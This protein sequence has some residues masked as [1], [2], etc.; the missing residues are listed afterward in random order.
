VRGA[1]AVGAWLSRAT[2]T[3]PGV[4]LGPTAAERLGV[5]TPGTRVWL[6]GQW[7]GVTGILSPIPLAPELD[8][9]ALVGWPA[10]ERYLGFDG[11]PTSV[12]VRSATAQVEAVRNVLPG[13]AN[14]AAPNEVRVSRPSDAL[15]ARR[16]TDQALGSLLLGLGAV[17]LLVGAIGVA[18]TMVISVLERRAEI[19]LRRSLGATSKQIRLQF[20]TESVL[21]S[22]L[23]GLAGVLLGTGVLAGG[24]ATGGDRRWTRGDRADRCPGRRLPCGP[25]V[26]VVADRGAGLRPVITAAPSSSHTRARR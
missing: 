11:R 21:L 20:L 1:T 22:A 23:G 16:A 10:A 13:T 7:F 15:A 4:V 26:P 12:Y 2:A 18:N 19:G 17:A 14:P 5:R 9:A 3:Y 24:T 8:T 6:G 25:G